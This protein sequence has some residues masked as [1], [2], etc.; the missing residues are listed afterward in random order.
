MDKNYKLQ[1]SIDCHSL[2]TQ[3]YMRKG[4]LLAYDYATMIM[5]SSSWE[6]EEA[7]SI[8]NNL[9]SN[10]ELMKQITSDD[11]AFIHLARITVD[12]LLNNKQL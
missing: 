7:K 1:R 9:A 5:V 11:Y 10:E 2:L 4:I 6:M 3:G 12:G 8:A